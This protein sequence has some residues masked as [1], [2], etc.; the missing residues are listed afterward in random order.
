MGKTVEQLLSEISSRELTE[1]A[2]YAQL[3]PFGDERADLR[4][5]IVASTVANFLRDAKKRRKPYRAGDFMPH[6]G[7]RRRES[8]TWQQ[9]LHLIEMLNAAL[10]GRDLR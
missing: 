2:A 8:Q 3:E 6:F 7:A 9:Q 10:G 1:W 5:G 4:A